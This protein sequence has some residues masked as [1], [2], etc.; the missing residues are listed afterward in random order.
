MR[1][2][3]CSWFKEKAKEHG[4][5]ITPQRTA[6]YEALALSN[7]HPSTEKVFRIVR[8]KYPNISFDTINRTLLTFSEIGLVHVVETMG[9]PRRYDPDLTS[10]DH[11]L[12]VK[13]WLLF[14]IFLMLIWFFFF[15]W[16]WDTSSFPYASGFSRY[17]LKWANYWG[18][19]HSI[20]QIYCKN[21]TI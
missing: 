13:S 7:Q 15:L 2:W 9:G 12:C 1:S 17:L 3:G 5:R 14:C 6:V 21:F 4:L 8:H 20:R 19:T 10:H 16:L 11:F 18:V